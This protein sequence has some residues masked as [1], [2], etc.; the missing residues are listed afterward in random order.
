MF[1]ERK[2][3]CLLSFV[4]FLIYTASLVAS[5]EDLSGAT[6]GRY[7]FSCLN[8]NERR[9]NGLDRTSFYIMVIF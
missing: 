7:S 2:D 6:V 3:S 9:T 8:E 5:I 1:I 4:L